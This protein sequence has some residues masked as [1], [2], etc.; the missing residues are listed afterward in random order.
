MPALLEIRQARFQRA[1]AER[2]LA[3]AVT[4]ARAEGLSW[5]K[6]GLALGTTGEAARQRYGR[7]ASV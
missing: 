5:H 7:L 3:D 2:H 6:V 1:Y 4:Q